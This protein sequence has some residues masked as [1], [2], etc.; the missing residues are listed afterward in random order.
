MKNTKLV[1][2]IAVLSLLI[3]VG[4]VYAYQGSFNKQKPNFDSEKHQAMMENKDAMMENKEAI[5]Q[6]IENNDYQTWSELMAGT[7]MAELINEGNFAR[8]VE[9]HSLANQIKLIKEELGLNF[10]KEGKE[11]FKGH[12]AGFKGMNWTK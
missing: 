3:T 11:F 12:R 10:G 5:N 7:K 6:A 2:P 1:I 4:T 9:M 8:F